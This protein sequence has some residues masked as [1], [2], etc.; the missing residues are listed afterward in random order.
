MEAANYR[1]HYAFTT[2]GILEAVTQDLH[3][4]LLSSKQVQS[5]RLVREE[6]VL[7]FINSISRH[8][9]SPINLS[10]SLSS[11]TYGITARAAFDKKCKEQDAF[12]SLVNESVAL[13][14]GFNLT[15]LFPSSKLLSFLN[16]T[17]SKLEKIHQ[18]FDQILNNIIEEHKNSTTDEGEVDKDLVDVFL[19]V[20]EHGDLEIPLSVDD[21]K[22]VILDMFSA[23]SETSTITVESAVSE[24]L[25]NPQIMQKAQ[26]D[27]RPVFDREG[28]FDETCSQ[29]LE[30][31][32]LV[33]K[34][35][36]EVAPL[37]A[38]CYCL[39]KTGRYARLM[40]LRYLSRLKL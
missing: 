36:L 4:G 1:K 22:A 11:L 26:A 15:Q 27:V 33:I 18:G 24:L 23:G 10:K 13:V 2:Q 21:M 17:Q 12:I 5:L 7:K 6:E 16:K 29:E 37:Q 9:G 19:K 35:T 8:P 28:P 3:F 20:Q 39:E 34:G 31:L 14:G 38:L 30:F 40:D 32:H 25:K